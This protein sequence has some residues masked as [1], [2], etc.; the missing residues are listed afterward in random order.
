MAIYLDTNIICR[1][2]SFGELDRL[3]L[4]IA[5]DQIGQM[6]RIPELVVIEASAIYERELSAAIEAFDLAAE[7]LTKEFDLLYT[8]TEPQPDPVGRSRS[9]R[10]H[11][12]DLWDV[13]PLDPADAVLA[14][15]YEVNGRPPARERVPKKKGSGARDAAI[16]LSIL[17]DHQARD[18]ESYFLTKNT[19][20]FFD[21]GQPK[22]GLRKDM[23]ALTRPMHLRVSIEALLE[24]L[25]AS[26]TDATIDQDEF[27]ERALPIVRD[28]LAESLV[29]P[30]AVFESLSRHRF[31][32]YVTSGRATDILRVR[33]FV[34]QSGSIL[35][36]DAKW[37][38]LVD[39]LYQDEPTPEPDRWGKLHDYKL[40]GRLQ[41]YLSE[42]DKASK[43]GQLIAAQVTSETMVG[44]MDDDRL[45]IIG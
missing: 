14:L 4:S 17:R 45:W 9:W 33:R 10:D 32:T 12:T 43:S 11:L 2:R 29:V 44:F 8:E 28:Q 1:W 34:H 27:T 21:D 23:A 26:E 40:N 42:D 3:A 15:E 41:V 13:V 19:K 6:I 30:R 24:G 31:R 18:E 25:G 38:L 39:L 20:D 36:V 35:M 16:W 22:A 5:A 37:E 7:E